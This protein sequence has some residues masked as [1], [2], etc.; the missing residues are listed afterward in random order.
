MASDTLM[1]LRIN[2]NQAPL[3]VWQPRTGSPDRGQPRPVPHRE[4]PPV[5]HFD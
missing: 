4:L 1:R 3:R 5:A 2:L